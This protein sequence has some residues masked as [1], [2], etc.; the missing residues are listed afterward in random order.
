MRWIM[1]KA[2][3]YQKTVYMCF[4][5]CSKAFDCVNHNRLWKA[6]LEL[7]IPLHLIQVIRS[8]YSEQE[9]AVRTPYGD[10]E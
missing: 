4:I 6:M 5:Y 8:L 2:R 3:E 9:A 1:E 7:G 10:T